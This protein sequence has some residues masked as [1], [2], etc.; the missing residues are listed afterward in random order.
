MAMTEQTHR[1]CPFCPVNVAEKIIASHAT[2]FA[3]DDTCPVTEGHSLIIPR[4]HVPDYFSM[5]STEKE[6]A[7]ALIHILRE[8]ILE[9]D[10]SVTG[11]NIGI[12][13]GPS[14]GQTIFHV[15][16]HLIP[17]RDGDVPNPSGGVRG[18]IPGKMH[19]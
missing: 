7:D 9:R 2:V 4:R 1:D 6:D 13:N 11:F 14:A 10:P 5:S 17:R 16:I 12:N 3:I 19:Y 8:Q 15:H 18:V